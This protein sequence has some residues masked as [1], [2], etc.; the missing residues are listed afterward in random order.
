MTTENDTSDNLF[1]LVLK[2]INSVLGPAALLLI[3]WVGTTLLEVRTD[4]SNLRSEV[5]Q[6]QV[7]V[8]EGVERGL[9]DQGRRLSVLEDNCLGRKRGNE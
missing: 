2:F 1:K 8:K 9:T 6:V 7:H 4:M 3:S 5:M